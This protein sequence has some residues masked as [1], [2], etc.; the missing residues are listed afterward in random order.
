[1][2]IS[3]VRKTEANMKMILTAICLMFMPMISQAG[4]T[5]IEDSPPAKAEETKPL[6]EIKPVPPKEKW[7]GE[8]NTTLKSAVNKWADKAKWQVIWN[9]GQIDYPLMVSVTF[10]GRID[11][12]V[13]GFIKLYE[14]A[15]NPLWVDVQTSQKLFY[16]TRKPQ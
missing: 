10:E 7:V 9:I 13:V 1:M 2:I 12:A 11:E 5:V 14:T 3:N 4:M 6:I 15:K 16:I 8:A